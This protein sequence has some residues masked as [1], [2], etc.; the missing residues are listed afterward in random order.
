MVKKY[1]LWLKVMV[2]RK[3]THGSILELKINAYRVFTY[4][5]A[6]IIIRL[7]NSSLERLYVL[8]F[9]FYV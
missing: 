7:R 1:M 2:E 9:K 4:L 6:D 5:L 3:M 8:V